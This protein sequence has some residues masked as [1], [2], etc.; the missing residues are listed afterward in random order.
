MVVLWFSTGLNRLEVPTPTLAPTLGLDRF[1]LSSKPLLPTS[2]PLPC[3]D[4]LPRLHN[5]LSV[6]Q[7]EP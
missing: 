2:H 3:L 4:V 6:S 5:G 1:S 7:K